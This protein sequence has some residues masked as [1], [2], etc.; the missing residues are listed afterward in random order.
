MKKEVWKDIRDYE[1]WYRVSS[2]G[3]VKSLTRVVPCN[4][5]TRIVKERILSSGKGGNGYLH[6]S[7]CK[8]S[9]PK[10]FSVHVLVAHAFIGLGPK[11]QEV[12]HLDGN[13]H[14]NYYKNLAYGTRKQ[15]F[16][17]DLKNDT[18]N[19]GE[20]N[21]NAKLA[22]KDVGEVRKLSLKGTE[23]LKISEIFE[24]HYDTIRYIVNNST[25]KPSKFREYIFE[26]EKACKFK[27]AKR[28]RKELKVICPKG[29]SEEN[30]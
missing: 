20:K 10:L 19:Y 6:V 3:H 21:G 13:S 27:E 25:W 5:G 14:N 16:S 4:G 18:N 22:F 24:V 30:K 23:I 26:L 17:D 1:G 9:K 2:H 7:L 15:N 12:R 29:W 11:D 8:G 28:V